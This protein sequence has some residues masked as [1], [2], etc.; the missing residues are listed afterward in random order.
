M[1][2][3]TTVVQADLSQPEVRESVS[4]LLTAYLWQTEQEKLEQEKAEQEKLEDAGPA[5]PSPR[6]TPD[7]SALPARYRAEIADPRAAFRAGDVF[8]ARRGQSPAGATE[9]VGLVVAMPVGPTVVEIK[10]LW[11]EPTARRSGLGSALI[12]AAVRRAA[13]NN[14]ETVRLTVWQWRDG[15]LA[16]YRKRGFVIS[17]EPWD[18]RPGLVCLERAIS[19]ED[20][21][22]PELS[23]EHLAHRVS[24][25]RV[26]ENH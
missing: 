1:P 26:D 21:I 15:A 23:F 4:R 13:E 12:R 16:S 18:A 20:S 24:G 2:E 17:A 11:V 8:L 5:T 22:G 9:A 25:Q 3:S 10:R 7:H 6:P 19:P 14:C